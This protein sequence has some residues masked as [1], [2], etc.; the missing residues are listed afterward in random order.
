MRTKAA[1]SIPA[2]APVVLTNVTMTDNYADDGAALH[3]YDIYPGRIRLRNSIVQSADPRRFTNCTGKPLAQSINNLINDESCG[4][5]SGADPL[6]GD[7]TGEPAWHPL[8]SGSPAQGAADARFCPE[9]DQVG[10]LRPRGSG[11]DIGA[12]EWSAGGS[13]PRDQGTSTQALADC[14][15][16]T[17]HVLNF[18]DGPGGTRCRRCAGACDCERQGADAGL[19][20]GR[21]SRQDR[22]DQRGL[23]RDE[24]RVRLKSQL[25]NR[26]GLNA[27][28][29]RRTEQVAAAGLGTLLPRDCQRSVEAST[30]TLADHIRS[31][32]SNTSIGGC[33]QGT[34]H[35]IITLSE[36]ITLGEALPPI[37]G[38]IT[39]EGNGHTIDGDFRHRILDVDGGR[40][41]V[42]NLTLTEL[43]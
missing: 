33:P 35:D 14:S 24:R 16:T 31:A 40:L 4:M 28:H 19:V 1:L 10:R 29:T 41:R 42:N 43:G 8:K 22:L 30:C 15:V 27:Q 17:T 39:I 9:T 34:S 6:I 18:R 20:P 37:T 21:V 13:A 32:N 38:T 5:A 11:C 36:D 25:E 26:R 7:L 23:R 3:S 12:I 2:A